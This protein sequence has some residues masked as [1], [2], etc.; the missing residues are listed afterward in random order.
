MRIDGRRYR[1]EWIPNTYPA[2]QIGSRFIRISRAGK[3]ISLTADEESQFNEFFM[4]SDLFDRFERTGHIITQKNSSRTFEDLRDWLGHSYD[5]P[6]LHIL[7]PTRRCNLNCTYCHMNPQP[8]GAERRET[9]LQPE[10]I[11][12]IVG[13]MLSSPSPSIFVEFQGGEPFLNFPAVVQVVDEVRRQNESANKK[14]T[15]GL[16]SNLMV[17][18]DEQL[19]Y[20]YENDIQ[21][22]YTLN[23]PRSMHNHFRITRNGQGSHDVVVRRMNHI[24]RSFP[25]LLTSHPLCVIAEDNMTQLRQMVDYYDELGFRQISSIRLKNLGNAVGQLR[26][27]AKEFVPYY[28]DMLEH[29]CDKN[30]HSSGGYSER[31][32]LLALRKIIGRTNPAFIDWR[33]PIGYVSNCIVYDTDGEILPVD[34]ARSLRDVFSLGN[35]RNM[36][37]DQLIRRKSSFLTVNLSI[38]DRDSVCRECTFNPYCGVSPVLHYSR[39]GDLVPEPHENEECIVILALF[40]WMFRKLDEDPM[41]LLKMLPESLYSAAVGTLSSAVCVNA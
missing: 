6:G 4:D 33:N 5:G 37:Y 3:A 7:V 21:L 41:P 23:G 20:C 34:E 13:F 39:T 40:E 24:K 1:D 2:K 30:R 17:S 27:D 8:V 32:A 9:D 38:R 28:L 31:T 19:R 35:V 15:F 25:G 16:V 29:I 12:Y 36:T 14:V 26:F 11:P 18:T 22:S 10:M